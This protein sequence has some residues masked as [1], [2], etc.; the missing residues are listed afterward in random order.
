MGGDAVLLKPLEVDYG[1]RKV[2]VAK[3]QR[4]GEPREGV[5]SKLEGVISGAMGVGCGMDANGAGRD[6]SDM[7][8]GLVVELPSSPI[9]VSSAVSFK[10]KG[11]NVN[12]SH[13][14]SKDPLLESMFLSHLRLAEF[15]IGED[16]FHMLQEAIMDLDHS[17]P[18]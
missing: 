3:T 9:L 2:H 8:R 6:R 18:T 13:T 1:L 11:G 15:D 12:N 16:R 14:T 17:S 5:T 10:V 4:V 7:G